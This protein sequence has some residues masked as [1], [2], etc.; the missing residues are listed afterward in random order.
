[1]S[2]HDIRDLNYIQPNRMFSVR[3]IIVYIEKEV[4]YT[5]VV[6]DVMNYNDIDGPSDQLIVFFKGS[7]KKVADT[8]MSAEMGVIILGDLLWKKDRVYLDGKIFEVFKSMKL[9]T[10]S[11]VFNV[12]PGDANYDTAY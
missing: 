1:M 7:A 10:A 11:N 4:K 5:K 12:S 8:A 3:G 2:L 6:L 9:S